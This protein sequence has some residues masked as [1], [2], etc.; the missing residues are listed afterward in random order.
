MR[1]PVT[2]LALSLPALAAAQQPHVV[3]ST[4]RPSERYEMAADSVVVPMRFEFGHIIVDVTIN[5]KGPFPFIFDTGAQGS[6]L[7]LPF[8]RDQGFELGA[9]VR[10]GS[11]NGGGRPGQM[12]TLDRVALGGL[13][14]R[15]MQSVA[16]EGLPFPRTAT[17]PRGVIG[18]YSLGGLLVAL[19]YPHERLIFTR[20][21]L[22]DPDGREVFGWD[23]GQ[24]LPLIPISVAG[25]SINVHLDSGAMNGLSLPTELA[26]DLPLASPPVKM[27]HTKGVDHESVVTGAPLNGTVTIGRYTL[28][29]PTVLFGDF[30]K[31]TGNVGPPI[32]RQFKL[33]I[34]PA[35]RRLELEGPADGRL[36]AV[37]EKVR[38]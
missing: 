8:A 2:L 37:A 5:G 14:F 30:F 23:A 3:R 4:H 13:T 36:Q 26:K 25:H 19:D 33:T 17:S 10:V 1:I 38:M 22:P 24:Q 21:A 18:P 11:P 31:T 29:H 9:E 28:D 35:H 12:V 34:D 15:G 32:L 20:G 7:D 6:V 16:F 27:G